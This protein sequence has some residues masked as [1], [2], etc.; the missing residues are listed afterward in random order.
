MIKD[1]GKVIIELGIQWLNSAVLWRGEQNLSD[2]GCNIE[3]H[4]SRRQGARLHVVQKGTGSASC[5]K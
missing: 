4:G 2:A 3:N 5:G 1:I